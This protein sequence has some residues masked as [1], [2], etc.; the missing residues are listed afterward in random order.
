MNHLLA[1]DSH[2]ISSLIWFLEAEEKFENVVRCKYYGLL[3]INCGML[4]LNGLS[5]L[6]DRVLIAHADHF[7]YSLK[8]FTVN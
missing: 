5:Y 2:G 6:S 7:F 8:L 4:K 3:I 1:D